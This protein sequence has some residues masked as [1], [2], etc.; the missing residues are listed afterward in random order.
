MARRNRKPDADQ[1]PLDFDARK[2]EIAERCQLVEAIDYRRS[3]LSRTRWRHVAGLLKA[4][5]CCSGPDGYSD[6][7]A[8]TLA[9]RCEV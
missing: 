6:A 1:L 9:E 8:D 7:Y 5:A 4:I 3:G 2:R